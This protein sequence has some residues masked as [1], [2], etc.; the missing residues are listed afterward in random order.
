MPAEYAPL[1]QSFGKVGLKLISC[2]HGQTIFLSKQFVI[3]RAIGFD[4]F[5]NMSQTLSVSNANS[6]R[7][8][9]ST[10]KESQA[11][12]IIKMWIKDRQRIV[13]SGRSL[14][15]KSTTITQ[16]LSEFTRSGTIVQRFFWDGVVAI[17]GDIGLHQLECVQFE[18]LQ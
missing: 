5:L 11:Q 7:S 18:I 13:I 4:Y 16:A 10:T 15:G 14:S 6:L 1:L 9:S 8:C 17:S 3:S 2:H 12:E